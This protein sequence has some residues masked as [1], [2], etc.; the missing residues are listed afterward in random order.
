MVSK[1]QVVAAVAG[2]GR[3]GAAQS[4]T[5]EASQGVE[6]LEPFVLANR[7][8]HV[9]KAWALCEGEEEKRRE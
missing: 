6:R 4:K 7:A 3:G 5:T 2:G 9:V 1:G 8:G